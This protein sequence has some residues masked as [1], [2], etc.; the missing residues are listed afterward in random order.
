ML[1]TGVLDDSEFDVAITIKET[2]EDAD[3]RIQRRL[4]WTTIILFGSIGFVYL[5][6]NYQYLY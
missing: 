6:S 2:Q 1:G 4:L 5:L 3:K